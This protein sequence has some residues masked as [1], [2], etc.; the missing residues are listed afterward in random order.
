[1]RHVNDNGFAERRKAA[2]EAKKLLLKK[3][4]TAP[5]ADDP[6]MVAKRAEREAISAA[7]ELRRAERERLKQEANERQLAEAAA[8]TEAA[9]A[10]ERAD[11]E[12]RESAAKDRI[13]RVIADEAERKA[14]R[15]RRYAARK[16]RQR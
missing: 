5:K 11:A 8:L 9:T 12:A 14:E 1:M 7:R 13:A 3:F 6:E 4:E 15:D 2:A 10:A 16:A